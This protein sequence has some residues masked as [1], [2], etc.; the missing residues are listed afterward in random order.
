MPWKSPNKSTRSSAGRPSRLN[1][2]EFCKL[3]AEAYIS[4]M[5]RT[6][7]AA[8]F[9]VSN[10]TVSTWVKDPRVVAHASRLTAERIHRITRRIDTEI[11]NRLQKVG[12]IDVD[13]LLKIRKE[14]VTTAMRE[15]THGKG[16]STAE[17]TNELLEAMDQSPDFAEQLLELANS[18]PK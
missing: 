5:G 7:M 4:G 6:E 17:T 11:E 10:P 13:L 8:E 2:P 3:V 14:F 18:A 1:D 9:D 12:D 16:A 15:T